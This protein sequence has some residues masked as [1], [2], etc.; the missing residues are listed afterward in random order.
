MWAYQKLGIQIQKT[1]AIFYEFEVYPKRILIKLNEMKY[2][3]FLK[4]KI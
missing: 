1:D 4:I 2:T 3:Y